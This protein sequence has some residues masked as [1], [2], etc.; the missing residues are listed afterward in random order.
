ML[1]FSSQPQIFCISFMEGERER[2]KV[3]HFPTLSVSNNRLTEDLDFLSEAEGE[4][5]L[6]HEAG[7]H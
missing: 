3:L 6:R 1:I 7:Y 2:G 4:Q 5:D